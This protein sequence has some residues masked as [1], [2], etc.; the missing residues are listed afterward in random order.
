LLVS[1]ADLVEA[2][3]D[4]GVAATAGLALK[5]QLDIWIAGRH[6]DSDRS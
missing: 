4:I 1:S 2:R 5:E 3:H 6:P